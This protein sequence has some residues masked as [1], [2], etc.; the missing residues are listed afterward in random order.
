MADGRPGVISGDRWLVNNYDPGK[1][2]M[3][4]PY[5][6]FEDSNV[7]AELITLLGDVRERR[8]R[9]DVERIGRSAGDKVSMACLG[10][11]TALA[12]DDEEIPRL[13]DIMEH[14]HGPEFFRAARR[15]GGIARSEDV[16]Q[17][18]KIYGQV[19]GSMRDEVKTALERTIS[20][21]P[22][23]EAKRDL[24]LSMPVYPD[25]AAFEKFLDSSRDYLDVRYRENVLPKAEISSSLY[26]NVAR[27]LSK[28]RTRM[29]NEADNLRY[30]GPDKED[31]YH[32]TSALMAWAADDLSHK[33]VLIPEREAKARTCPRCG[34]MLVC[35][36]GIWMCPDCG[37]DLRADFKYRDGI[38]ESE[39][40]R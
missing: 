40:F 27:A 2:P 24:I 18:R 23:L 6:E 5:L 17:L 34:G 15:M 28:M 9:G 25:E 35:Y 12:Q 16:P 7:S 32:E 21:D 20:R 3:L 26:N 33:K 10:Y 22:E 36:K 8:I 37:G 39:A 31:R 4:R 14:D 1:L 38:G 29:Y 19:G 30:Y 13:F 11:L